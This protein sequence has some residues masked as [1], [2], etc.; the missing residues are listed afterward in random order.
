CYRDWSSDVCSSDLEYEFE[1]QVSEA[2][3]RPDFVLDLRRGDSHLKVVLEVKEFQ[4]APS[5]FALGGGSYDPYGAIREKIKEGTKKFR[6][7]KKYLCGLV[8]YKPAKQL[9]ALRWEFMY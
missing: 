9:V 1:P 3:K 2:S 8:L 5:D 4:P 6:E 7:Y